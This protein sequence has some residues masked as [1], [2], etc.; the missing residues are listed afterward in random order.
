LHKI[1]PDTAVPRYRFNR[2]VNAVTRSDRFYTFFKHWFIHFYPVIVKR[3]GI[4]QIDFYFRSNADVEGKFK[5]RIGIPVYFLLVF[6]V[7]KGI[8]QNGYFFLPQV[9]SQAVGEQVID[10]FRK[11]WFGKPFWMRGAG[12]F[13]GLNPGREAF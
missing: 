2:K 1:S 6:K 13:P 12:T 7:R 4:V 10:F 3:N 8:A 11:N 5:F 9:I